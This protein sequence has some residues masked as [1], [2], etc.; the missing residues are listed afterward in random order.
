VL[1]VD[2]DEDTAETLA[3][4]LE[5]SGHEVRMA[6]DGPAALEAALDYRPDVMLLDIGLPMLNGFEV[7]DR[8][9]HEPSLQTTVLVAV[10]GYGQERDRK[11]TAQAGFNYHLVKPAD[12]L[13]VQKILMTVAATRNA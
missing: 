2:D 12:F 9:R 13:D 8:L 6:H 1:I 7:A 11:R 5:S 4:L 3:M 10:T